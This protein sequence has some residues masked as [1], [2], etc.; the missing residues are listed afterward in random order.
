MRLICYA[1]K[2]TDD[3]RLYQ[4][5]DLQGFWI[6][7]P[8]LRG[9]AKLEEF[10]NLWSEPQVKYSNNDNILFIHGIT[11]LTP[12]LIEQGLC[13]EI[14]SST[15]EQVRAGSSWKVCGTPTIIKSYTPTLNQQ[16]KLSQ[17]LIRRL[18]SVINCN[19]QE[20]GSR[21]DNIYRFVDNIVSYNQMTQCH[22]TFLW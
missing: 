13:Q 21:P 15:L 17:V 3:T 2:F 22:I 10:G 12:E 6:V 9:T 16:P 11:M 7:G 4:L 20:K 18:Y 14:L 1:R 19:F 8:S 5:A